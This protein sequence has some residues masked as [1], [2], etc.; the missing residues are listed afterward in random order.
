LYRSKLNQTT[1]R[2]FATD[3][4]A[5]SSVGVFTGFFQ[6]ITSFFIGAGLTAVGTQYYL[7]EEI[8]KSNAGMIAKQKEIEKRLDMLEKK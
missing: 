1:I 4:V 5:K 3:T 6:R 7:Y 2:G 8:K